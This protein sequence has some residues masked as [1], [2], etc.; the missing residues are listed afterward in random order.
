MAA[1]RGYLP[2]TLNLQVIPLKLGHEFL[3][4]MGMGREIFENARLK[5]GKH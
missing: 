5:I 2:Q 4:M 3:R 1:V